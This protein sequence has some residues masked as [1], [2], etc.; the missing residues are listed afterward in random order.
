MKKRWTPQ[1][2]E[3]L[4]QIYHTMT[5]RQL[6]HRF[7]TTEASIHQKCWKLGLRKGRGHAKIRL[8]GS[9]ALWLRINFPHMRN[10]LCAMHLGISLRTVVRIARE[11]NLEKTPQFMKECQSF[12]AQ[13]A[14]QSHLRNGT[15][16]PKGFYSPNLQKGEIYRFKPKA[17]RHDPATLEI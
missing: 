8:K 16:P 7:N 12:T 11:M 15:Y 2:T 4:R 5:A 13:K 6:A 10:E 1:Q 3:E 14:R 9:D 17:I